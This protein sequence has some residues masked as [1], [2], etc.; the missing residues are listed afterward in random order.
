MAIPSNLPTGRR[1]NLA[2]ISE[3][4][5]LLNANPNPPFF[6]VHHKDAVGSW[7]VETEGLDGPTWLPVLCRVPITPGSANHRTVSRGEPP[8]AA[9]ELAHNVL[10]Q[11]GAIVLPQDISAGG[12]DG[13]MM[14]VDCE[15]VENGNVG[16]RGL[17]YFEAWSTPI[18]PMAGGKVRDQIDRAKHNIFRLALVEDGIIPPPH[19]DVIRGRMRSER[20]RL[21]ASEARDYGSDEARTRNLG[22]ARARVERYTSAVIPDRTEVKV[23]A[24][25]KTTKPRRTSDV[26]A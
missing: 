19:A 5:A 12:V 10:R 9:Y 15:R 7:D 21:G 24:V 22:A 4:S 16:Q 1:A 17:Y 2:G 13:Y 25:P 6:L 20:A 26:E 18:P 23:V 14:E 11:S 3:G 8:T